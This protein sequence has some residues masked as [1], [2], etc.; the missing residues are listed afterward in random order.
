MKFSLFTEVQCPSGALP[1][2]RL[3]DFLT[4]AERA[5]KLG[6]HGIWISELH[7]QPEFSVFA[8]PY[9]VL[10]AV[11]QRTQRLRMGVA[12]NIL[13]VHHPLQLAEQAAMIDLLSHGRMDFAI[14]MGHFH[15]R[16]YEG[17]GV[18]QG[19]GREM[20]E[21][22]VEVIRAAWTRDVLEHEGRFYRIPEVMPN[23]RPVQDPPPPIYT[24][25][26]SPDGIE[27]AARL[28]LNLLLPVH[29]LTRD[30]V[31]QSAAYYWECLEKQGRNRSDGELGLLAPV[32]V[33][34]TTSKAR[35]RAE[36]GILDYYD[37]IRKV[38]YDYRDWWIRRG[39]D[40]EKLRRPAWEGITYERICKEHAV[41]FDV[42]GAVEEIQSLARDTGANH[43]LCWMNMGSM[44]QEMVLDSMERFAGDVMPRLGSTST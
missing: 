39:L 37:V 15:S 35:E 29:T 8:A 17:F 4:Q 1:V 34:E 43:I 41:L 28:G 22:S 10:G 2:K 38:R 16:V 13:P 5:D 3:E 40:P 25:T 20:I 11:T 6:Y 42:D 19:K 18:E 30:R 21:E 24:A 7:F 14:G 33:A 36:R 27:L 32:H 44:T 31:K 12:V 9:P 23:P 26:G